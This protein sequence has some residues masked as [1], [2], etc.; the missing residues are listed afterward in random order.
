M[1]RCDIWRGENTFAVKFFYCETMNRIF[2]ARPLHS[3]AFVLGRFPALPTKISRSA[4]AKNLKH[5]QELKAK[6]G[7]RYSPIGRDKRFSP[8]SENR[9]P[10]QPSQPKRPADPPV[11]IARF[12]AA[13]HAPRPLDFVPGK[14]D[15]SL[16][17]LDAVLQQEQLTATDAPDQVSIRDFTIK[18]KKVR[19]VETTS[20]TVLSLPS[21]AIPKDS[22]STAKTAF[23]P[24]YQFGLTPKEAQFLFDTAAQSNSSYVTKDPYSMQNAEIVR[25]IISIENASQKSLTA[26]N[27]TRVKELFQRHERDTGSSEVQGMHFR[28]RLYFHWPFLILICIVSSVQPQNCN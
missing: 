18:D 7:K 26:F 22:D 3:T 4:H 15:D 19:K 23:G 16:K 13:P 20:T 9:S 17:T 5:I 10:S 11:R 2:G 24:F 28:I 8:L 1:L 12:L 6:L 14:L 27:K 25:R 21:D